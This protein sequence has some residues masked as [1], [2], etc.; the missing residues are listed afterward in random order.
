MVFPRVSGLVSVVIA[1]YNYARYIP[2]C[3]ESLCGQTYPHMEIV[4]VDDASTDD[5]SFAIESWKTNLDSA[6][7]SPAI[8]SMR[9]PRHVGYAGALTTGFFLAQGE[10]IAVQDFDDLS[11]PSRIEKQVNHLKHNTDVDLIG[12][13]VEIFEDGHF[14]RRTKSN[15]IEYGEDI[16]KSFLLGRPAICMSSV[17]FR[18]IIFDYLGGLTR[19]H[20]GMEDHHFISK[21][22]A[23]GI[24]IDNI[25]DVLYY[26]R[27]HVDRRSRQI[28]ARLR[29]S[30][31]QR[32]EYGL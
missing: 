26:T 24:G 1:S 31:T 23:N 15:L 8:V 5:T 27:D 2:Q 13:N 22:A 12:T 17:L 32:R 16:Q 20:L 21:C 29:S 30:S 25:R 4:I 7:V 11:A 28:Q 14:D 19:E 9:L 10:Y 18:G 3:L 6:T